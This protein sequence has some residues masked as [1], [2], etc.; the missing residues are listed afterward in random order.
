MVVMQDFRSKK[1]MNNN[2]SDYEYAIDIIH[3]L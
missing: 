2:Y 3:V 1:R